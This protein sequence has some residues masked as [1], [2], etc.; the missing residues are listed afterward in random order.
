M[1]GERA[2]T[3]ANSRPS[4]RRQRPLARQ[5]THG[6][7][8]S[9]HRFHAGAWKAQP[10]PRKASGGV[11]WSLRP[12]IGD[13]LP[14]S[15]S[16]A[17]ERP[18]TSCVTSAQEERQQSPDTDAG[19]AVT[20]LMSACLAAACGADWQPAHPCPLG[21]GPLTTLLAQMFHSVFTYIP[22]VPYAAGLA[23]SWKQ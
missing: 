16:Q 9:W 4:Q 7:C 11:R 10:R 17:S 21:E 22:H 18:R 20:K 14:R 8:C 6:T 15:R 3:S 1:Q 23:K 2:T 19:K 5:S 12:I 13:S